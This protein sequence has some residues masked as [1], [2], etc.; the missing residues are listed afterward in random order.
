[1]QKKK[2]I[3]GCAACCSVHLHT[4]APAGTYEVNAE[5]I[6]HRPRCIRRAAITDNNFEGYILLFFE[7]VQ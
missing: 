4:P 5:R 6:R 7:I 2:I 1:M 3:A